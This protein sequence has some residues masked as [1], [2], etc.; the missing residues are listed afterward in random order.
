M[1]IMSQLNGSYLFQGG[2]L[3]SLSAKELALDEQILLPSAIDYSFLT[4]TLPPGVIEEL[5]N[6]QPRS[7][8]SLRRMP[9]VTDS[10]AKT[11]LDFVTRSMRTL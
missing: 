6:V 4:R 3:K 8:A 1:Q 2:P 11:V 7:L 5:N 9:G 10:S